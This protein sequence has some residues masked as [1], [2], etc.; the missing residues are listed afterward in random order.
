M[1]K[2]LPNVLPWQDLNMQYQVTANI[3]AE[4]CIGCQLYYTA[5]EDGA[6]QA[7]RLHAGTR[8]PEIIAEN[9]VGCNLCLLICP[10]EECI[11]MD[12][13]DNGTQHFTWKERIA[14]GTA[15]IGCPRRGLPSA[16]SATR[17]CPARLGCMPG[18][19]KG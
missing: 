2:A 19:L 5:C 7:I 13:T 4:K 9:C 1:G 3:Y 18:K 17:P 16:K 11:T 6:H 10:V 14:A 12:R 15:T 8:M